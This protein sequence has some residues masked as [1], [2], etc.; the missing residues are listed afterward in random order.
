[1]FFSFFASLCVCVCV[2]VIIWTIQICFSHLHFF[3]GG[4][5]IVSHRNFD[6][7]VKRL[8]RK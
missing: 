3:N 6:C 8:Q 4:L 1:V 5:A 7:K 2:C